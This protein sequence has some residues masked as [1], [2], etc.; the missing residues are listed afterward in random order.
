MNLQSTVVGGSG[1]FMLSTTAVRGS[2]RSLVVLIVIA[3]TIAWEDR[4]KVF[5]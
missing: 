2:L 3:M 1:T 5:N 4:V